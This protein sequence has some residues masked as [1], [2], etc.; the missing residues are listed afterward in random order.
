MKVSFLIPSFNGL[1][2]LQKNLPAVLAAASN[3]DE[4]IVIED[5]GDDETI[6]FYTQQ[7]QL[8]LQQQTAQ[9]NWWR[10][11]IEGKSFNLIDLV[12]N[13]RFARAVNIGA[14]LAS[15]DLIF[16]LNN[17]V[18]PQA[19]ARKTLAK[20]F[21]NN[22]DI[23]AVAAREIEPAS[24]KVSGRNSLWWQRGRFWHRGEKSTENGPTAWASGGSAMFDRKKWLQIGGFDDRYYPAYWEDIDLAFQAKKRGWQILFD[25]K[26]LVH[27]HHETTNQSVFGQR[28]IAQM[29]FTNGTRFAWKNSRLRQKLSFIFFAP[30]WKLKNEPL[31]WSWVLVLIL[32]LVLRLVALTN[33]PAGLTVDE[34][35]IGYN[36]IAIA[37]AHRDEWLNFMPVSFR[38]FGDYKAPFA[39]YLAAAQFFIMPLNLFTLRLPFVFA[40][41]FSI[42][43]MMKIVALITREEKHS[44]TLA[45]TT[46][47]ALTLLPWH[48]HFGYLGFEA[49]YALAFLT[50]GVYGLLKFF[51]SPI[52]WRGRQWSQQWWS[53]GASLSGLSLALALYSYH[54]SKIVVPLLLLGFLPL[55]GREILQRW[56]V[57]LT[58]IL[59]SLLLLFPLFKDQ[60]WG[61]GLTRA[62]SLFIFDPALTFGEKITT[63]FLNLLH[64][65]SPSFLLFGATSTLVAGDGVHGV[66]NP[67]VLV[68]ILLSLGVWWKMKG[69]QKS[70]LLQKFWLFALWWLVSG[71]LP[72]AM[73]HETPHLIRTFL[74]LPGL[75]IAFVLGLVI[76]SRFS[77]KCSL[78]HF[79]ASCLRTIA[80]LLLF[81]F[82]GFWVAYQRDY[83]HASNHE[84]SYSQVFN[85]GL[86][87][88]FT[89]AKSFEGQVDR[90]IVSLPHEHP[91]I[92][93]LFV[94]HTNPIA[95]QGGNLS[96]YYDFFERLSEGDIA[97]ENVLLISGRAEDAVPDPDRIKTSISIYGRHANSNEPAKIMLYHLK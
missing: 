83:P 22:A 16:L 76:L 2:L 9:Y 15:G 6:N 96:G 60:I 89:I 69:G 42:W 75:M 26:A 50:W 28:K 91:Y 64:Y 23:F 39:I 53:W 7:Y 85:E 51:L 81:I 37:R 4:I 62:S 25:V 35:A 8:K 72:A 31:L 58:A 92:Q 55:F 71:F 77:A 32:A 20:H 12:H 3:G 94:R 5:A 38:S 80:I 67:I 24:G 27:H 48:F 36:G 87:Q 40:S 14:K 10:G 95:Y 46:G 90:I 86:Y 1:Q 70:P 63:T 19:S 41:V 21:E 74:A 29:S 13:Q 66:L 65:F 52:T 11:Q 34:A 18:A 84:Q 68:V 61:E 33:A 30:Y 57:L 45:A 78:K 88:A 82:L 79:F 97:K 47:L 73:S 17:D 59:P 56:K 43:A 93:A 44:L 49:N 54:S